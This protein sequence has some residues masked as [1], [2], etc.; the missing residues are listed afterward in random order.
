MEFQES[1]A[2]EAAASHLAGAE[3]GVRGWVGGGRYA[4]RY[5]FD[6]ATRIDGTNKLYRNITAI[7]ST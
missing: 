3:V 7:V 6:L 2:A 1:T 5:G 4:Y